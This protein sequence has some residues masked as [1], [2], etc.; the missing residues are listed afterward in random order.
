M[1]AT[2]FKYVSLITHKGIQNI[3]H[4]LMKLTNPMDL[5]HGTV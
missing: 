4:L 5:A 3:K 2:I 1:K